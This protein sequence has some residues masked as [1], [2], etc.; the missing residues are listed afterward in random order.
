MKKI[1]ILVVLALLVL[2]AP[3]VSGFLA[4]A[5]LESTL[6]AMN[7]NNADLNFSLIRFNQGWLGSDVEITV[8]LAGTTGRAYQA[9]MR[10]AGK[11]G[12]E[13]FKLRFR[14]RM[15]HGPLP[16]SGKN[17]AFRP[18][19]AGM[20][21]RLV[22]IPGKLDPAKLKYDMQMRMG[23]LGGGSTMISV[24]S[25]KVDLAGGA[26][27]DWKGGSIRLDYDTDLTRVKVKS[28]IPDISLSSSQGNFS[29]K[30][31]KLVSETR[32]L[33]KDLP[34]GN[35]YFSID[36][37][38]VNV[39][40]PKKGSVRFSGLK[41]DSNA[42]LKGDVVNYKGSIVLKSMRINEFT[43][44][45]LT[46]NLVMKNLHAES[47]AKLR[48]GMIDM[49]RNAGSDQEK[50]MMAMGLMFGTMGPLLEHG[51][52]FEVTGVSLKTKYGT[53]SGKMLLT[54]DTSNKAA[55]RNMF[56]VK[57]TI[58]LNAEWQIPEALLK[59]LIR[60]DVR[61]NLAAAG[62]TPTDDEINAGLNA[63]LQS[64]LVN[65]RFGQM[66][67]LENGV[68]RMRFSLR[69]GRMTLNGKPY[70]PRMPVRRRLH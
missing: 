23:I 3:G 27:F 31:L 13:P 45:P 28:D 69:K 59:E 36:D 38:L 54:F 10:K 53:M 64:M 24:P 48:R 60:M 39:F 41:V 50:A 52:L 63:R 51:P 9:Y 62:R 70:V 17:M 7:R 43:G 61:K 8:E 30:G 15:Q 47:L 11:P 18:M 25:M 4:K 1:I 58:I 42:K 55:L 66:F 40:G 46:I 37:I 20:N 2:A 33:V 22:E 56:T 19:L 21:M 67:R 57:D 32:E 44:G 26:V 34:V 16:L 68:Y 5:R 14:G 65:S 29:M 49:N 6:E 12:T 35:G